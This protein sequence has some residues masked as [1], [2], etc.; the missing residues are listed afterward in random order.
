M[1]SWK[2]FYRKEKIKQGTNR[3]DM[4]ANMF[5]R[6]AQAR[7]HSSNIA[8][9]QICENIRLQ[10]CNMPT[11]CATC[12]HDGQTVQTWPTMLA[13]MF[14]RFVH[15]L[16][17]R[18]SRT[19]KISRHLVISRKSWTIGPWEFVSDHKIYSATAFLTKLSLNVATQNLS[20]TSKRP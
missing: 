4:L 10:T 7:Q 19:M 14:E 8:G 17:R 9:K 18:S 6:F 1:F 13:N 16:R 3:S 5:K 12:Q 15:A 2:C 20:L 11:C